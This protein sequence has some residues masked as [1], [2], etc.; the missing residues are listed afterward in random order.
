MEDV[1]VEFKNVTKRFDTR[2][3][4]DN[5]NLKIYDNHVTTIIGKSGTGKSV[6]LKHI[7][8]LLEPTEGSIL[9]RGK[10]INNL[11]KK[12]LDEFRSQF[13]YCFQNNAL[14]DSRTVLEN[15]ALPLQQT[16]KLSKK[17]IEKKVMDKVEQ[18]ELSEVAYKYPSEISGGMQKRV[19][20]ARALITD[21][22]IVLFDEPTT[23]QDPIRK[24]AILGMISQNQRKFGFTTVMISHEIPDVFFISDRILIL[25]DGQII[26]QGSYNELDQLEHPMV[27]EFVKS[28]EGFQDELTGLHSKKSFDGLYEKSAKQ[29]ESHETISVAVF[30]LEGFDELNDKLGNTRTLE[31]VQA[32]GETVNKHFGQVG[33]STRI[34]SDQIATI[35]PNTDPRIAEQMLDD[36]SKNVQDQGLAGIQAEI[37]PGAHPEGFSFS[38]S[39][40]L[41]EGRGDEKIEVLSGLARSSKKT[42]AL[43]PC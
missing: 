7:I 13:S 16:M 35:L 32:L 42:V 4:L 22:K 2:T 27:D 6:L 30:V 28:L 21:P 14:F 41:A 40:G 10:P 36:F 39:A 37:Q 5:V 31:I 9:F 38:I 24:N 25:Y 3:I 18:M 17:E 20:L 11:K 8:G 1:L 23:G 26:F 19:A 43:F 33:I 12:E 15:I 34:G 29:K